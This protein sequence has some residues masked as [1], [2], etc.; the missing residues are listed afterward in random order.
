MNLQIRHPRAHALARELAAKR[1]ISMT[2]AV[3]A[4]LEAELH[5][6]AGRTPL[7][8]RARTIASELRARSKGE[9]RDMTRDEID[10]MWGHG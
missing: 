5:R 4:A 8:E 10:A 3:I 6:E 1:K 9:G 2:E 7:A